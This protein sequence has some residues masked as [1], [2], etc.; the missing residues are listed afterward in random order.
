MSLIGPRPERPELEQEL[1]ARIPH[2]RKR[3]WMQR[4]LSGWAQVCAPYAASVEDSELK[5]SYDL[6]Y[7]KHFSTWLDLLILLRTIKTVLKVA[8]Q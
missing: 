4:G 2:Y 5:L 7:L 6:Y 1:E 3:H 8:G